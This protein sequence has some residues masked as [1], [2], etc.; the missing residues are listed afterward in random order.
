MYQGITESGKQHKHG[1]GL[2]VQVP[3]PSGF[4]LPFYLTKGFY[5]Q[6]SKGTKDCNDTQNHLGNVHRELAVF[7][8][9]WAL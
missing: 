8:G 3:K 5:L 1:S 7:S 9:L 2:E 6:P 4:N